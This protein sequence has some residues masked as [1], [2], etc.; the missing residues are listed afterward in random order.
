MIDQEFR[1][2]GNSASIVNEVEVCQFDQ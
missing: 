1:S 2:S